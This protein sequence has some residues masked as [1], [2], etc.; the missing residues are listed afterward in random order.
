MLRRI[1][2]L[3]PT[4]EPLEFDTG[5]PTFFPDHFPIPSNPFT[6]LQAVIEVSD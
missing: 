2:I 1:Q 4:G 6:Q 3:L 5:N